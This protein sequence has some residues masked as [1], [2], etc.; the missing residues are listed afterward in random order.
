MMADDMKALC[1]IHS[2]ALLV[3]SLALPVLAHTNESIAGRAYVIDG[4][5]IVIQKVHIRLFG[6]DAPESKQGFTDATD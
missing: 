2:F 5:T 4:D 1:A 6:I 3:L